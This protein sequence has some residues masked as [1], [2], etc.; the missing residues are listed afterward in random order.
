[1]QR[2]FAGWW[3]APQAEPQRC[4]TLRKPGNAYSHG[5]ASGPLESTMAKPFLALVLL[6]LGGCADLPPRPQ[7]LAVSPCTLD[8]ASYAC[9]VERYH[10]V[11]V[12]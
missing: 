10:N 4:A 7:Y 11:S 8:E 3:G 2:P 5:T 9:Q 1:M 6:A 12:P